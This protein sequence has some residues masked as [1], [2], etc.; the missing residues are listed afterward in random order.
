MPHPF[1]AG[2]AITATADITLTADQVAEQT[3]WIIDPGGAGRKVLLP[4]EASSKGL[5][6][7]I[8]NSADAAEVLT[9]R[10]DVDPDDPVDVGLAVELPPLEKVSE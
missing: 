9:R 1:S 7:V 10:H 5:M 2:A 8:K 3:I 6:L 4:A